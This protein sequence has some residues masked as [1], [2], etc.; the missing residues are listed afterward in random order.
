VLLFSANNSQYL[1]NPILL[2]IA[3]SPA[4]SRSIFTLSPIHCN[5]EV[6]PVFWTCS[7][8]GEDAV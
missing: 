6:I 7:K 5:L 8:H 4:I 1:F 2:C 3:H